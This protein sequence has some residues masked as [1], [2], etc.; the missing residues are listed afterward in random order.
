MEL[1]LCPLNEGIL[2]VTVLHVLQDVLM[3]N[4]LC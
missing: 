2:N 1:V 4:N 3:C